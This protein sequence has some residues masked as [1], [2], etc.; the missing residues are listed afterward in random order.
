MAI[1]MSPPLQS[2]LASLPV[3]AAGQP[4]LDQIEQRINEAAIAKDDADKLTAYSQDHINDP[5][6]HVLLGRLYS[7][8]NF[9]E[10][11]SQE[12]EAAL[13]INR[14]QPDVWILLINEKYRHTKLT[15]AER[16][17]KEA[18]ALF[19]T[20]PRLLLAK[21]SL[22]I[23]LNRP[24][25]A[26][27]Q[28]EKALSLRQNDPIAYASLSEALYNQSRFSEALESANK[29]LA[30]RPDYPDAHLRR[31]LALLKLK[32][33]KEALA[34]LSNGYKYGP[35]HRELVTLYANESERQGNYVIALEASLGKMGLDV[36]F[37]ELLGDDKD[38]VIDMIDLCQTKGV[39]EEEVLKT[40]QAVSSKLKG[41]GH[42][43][44]YFFCLGDI[45]DAFGKREIAM[46]FY[47]QGLQVEPTYGRAW[48]RLGRDLELIHKNEEALDC[49]RKA[50]KYKK[51]DPE[52][53]EQL[54]KL[55]SRRN[56]WAWQLREFIWNL[57][58]SPSQPGA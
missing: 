1:L 48:L 4:E 42:Q 40:I 39:N 37:D 30:L 3:K 13:K 47:Q 23:H 16:L 17:M 35:F 27:K 28:L 41:T 49:Y 43:G 26:Q 9:G 21:G 22:L 50:I 19:P 34:S 24:A 38:K 29:A 55:E 8:Y 53:I 18:E 36:N 31:A 54:R 12:F 33:D 25:D 51:D 44:K 11:A 7:S 5:R 57:L 58:G 46:G 32:R 45:Y 10:M 20:N 52:I 15:D 2:T 6:A 56:D 14:D